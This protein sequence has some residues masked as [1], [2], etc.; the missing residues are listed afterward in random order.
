MP[1]AVSTDAIAAKEVS[2]ME[3][4]RSGATS[5]AS[6]CSIVFR[7]VKAWS[8]STAATLLRIGCFQRR[9]CHH[10]PNHQMEISPGMLFASR[11]RHCLS[12][13]LGTARCLRQQ[14]HRRW[15]RHRRGHGRGG[16]HRLA[17]EQ[18]LLANRVR[19][20]EMAP[21]HRLVDDDRER[22][23]LAIV[24]GQYAAINQTE[25]D[26]A[27]IRGADHLEA[28]IQTARKRYDRLS[29]DLNQLEVRG[30]HRWDRIGERHVA[31]ARQRPD[32]RAIS[33]R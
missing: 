24:L 2:R 26:G 20:L 7:F 6:S 22:R 11:I 29:D 5:S 13:A 14:P 23:A 3:R 19:P 21:R 33:S 9:R 30:S 17:L 18:N 15:S 16:L 25:P 27:K 28:G 12:C 31:D 1:N 10:R 8:R 32:T 4:S